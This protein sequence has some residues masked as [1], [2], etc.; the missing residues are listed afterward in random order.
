MSERKGNRA[1]VWAIVFGVFTIVALFPVSGT[2]FID[3]G[4]ETWATTVV[5]WT[6]RVPWDQNRTMADW[7]PVVA[8]LAAG[9]VVGLLVRSMVLFVNRPRGPT[10]A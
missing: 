5:G 2:S 6:Y 3:G 4:G 10:E 9:I 7:F 1:Y 8:P